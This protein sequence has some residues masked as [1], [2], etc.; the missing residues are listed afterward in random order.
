MNLELIEKNITK[1]TK[2]ILAVHIYGIPVNMPKLLKL[3]KKYRLKVIEDASEQIGQTINGS[4]CGS[5]GDI[6]TFS[7]YTNKHITTVE[8]G[9]IFTN[10]KLFKINV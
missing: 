1:K 5:F 4:Q 2:V 10:N 9:M 3:A 8:G 7:F 6:S